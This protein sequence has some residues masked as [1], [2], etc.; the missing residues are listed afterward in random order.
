[1]LRRVVA[2]DS[3]NSDHWLIRDQ[4]LTVE[5][6]SLVRVAGTNHLIRC[7][8]GQALYGAHVQLR[9]VCAVSLAERSEFNFQAT[10]ECR[11]RKCRPLQFLAGWRVPVCLLQSMLAYQIRQ[12]SQ[13]AAIEQIV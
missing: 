2:T 5:A 10:L 1:M 12:F 7:K 4:W 3:V 6:I 11:G 13:S 9:E 8:V